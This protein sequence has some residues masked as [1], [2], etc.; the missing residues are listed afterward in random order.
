VEAFADEVGVPEEGRENL[1]PYG[2][3]VFN[4]QGPRN[5]YF[6]A[7]MRDAAEVQEWIM[8]SCRR[9]NLTPGGFGAQIYEAADAGE[10]SE[11]QPG[12]SSARFSPPAWTPPSA[13]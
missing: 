11:E 9:E 7:A 12:C 1:L 8:A 3:M 10:I 13:L 2:D 4:G 5:E 6:Q